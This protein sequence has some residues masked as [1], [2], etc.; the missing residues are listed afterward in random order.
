M[1]KLTLADN[2]KE[3][4][5]ALLKEFEI[6]T[7]DK[8]IEERLSENDS[9]KAREELWEAIRKNV[10]EVFY[11]MKKQKSNAIKNSCENLKHY[12]EK[13]DKYNALLCNIEEIA[14]AL[15]E[16]DLKQKLLTLWSKV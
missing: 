16:C 11:E 10:V 3:V 8:T 15:P 7:D 4:L 1:E 9:F 6:A 2:A 5:V 13:R 14:Q 12:E